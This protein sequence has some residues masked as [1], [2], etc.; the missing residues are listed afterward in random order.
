MRNPPNDW[1]LV[2]EFRAADWLQGSNALPRNYPDTFLTDPIPPYI[3]LYF[4]DE[5]VRIREISA[6][7]TSIVPVRNAAVRSEPRIV[8]GLKIPGLILLLGSLLG[9]GF[10]RRHRSLL[11]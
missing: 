2:L 8:P 6:T 11:K 7:I 1:N 4:T 10:W 3:E 9:T 5:F